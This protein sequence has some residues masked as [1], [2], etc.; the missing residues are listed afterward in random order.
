MNTVWRSKRHEKRKNL[1]TIWENKNIMKK[2]CEEIV[3]GKKI[4]EKE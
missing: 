4:K 1:I 3:W 2:K